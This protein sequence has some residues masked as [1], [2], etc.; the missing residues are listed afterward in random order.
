MSENKRESEETGGVYVRFYGVHPPTPPPILGWLWEP[1]P[2]ETG[3]SPL[4]KKEPHLADPD[5][6]P[7]PPT[8]VVR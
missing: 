2:A 3:M 1:L 7:P 8:L 6:V 5:L 4:M